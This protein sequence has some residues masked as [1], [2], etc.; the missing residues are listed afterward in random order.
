MAEKQTR[1]VVSLTDFD[2][3]NQNFTIIDIL[4]KSG[5]SSQSFLLQDCYYKL[6]DTFNERQTHSFDTMHGP[7]GVRGER[8]E[9]FFNC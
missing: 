2:W 7:T 5:Q 9:G 6:P 4:P 8:G 3:H 1:H